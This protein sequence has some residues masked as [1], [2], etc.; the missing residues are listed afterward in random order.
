MVRTE[1]AC[2]KDGLFFYFKKIFFQKKGGYVHRVELNG[3][4]NKVEM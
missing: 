2:S 1:F 4:V 3:A